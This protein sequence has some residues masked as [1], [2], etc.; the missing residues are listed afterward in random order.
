MQNLGNN[1]IV[2]WNNLKINFQISSKVTP[3]PERKQTTELATNSIK[4][5]RTNGKTSKEIKERFEEINEVKEIIENNMM[6]W[7]AVAMLSY[8][9]GKMKQISEKK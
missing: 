2:G 9:I 7:L 5:C 1:K 4:S 8:I 3:A 6:M